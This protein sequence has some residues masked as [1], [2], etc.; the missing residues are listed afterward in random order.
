MNLE[1]SKV[2]TDNSGSIEFAE[3][4]M[5]MSGQVTQSLIDPRFV[6][7]AFEQIY[8]QLFPNKIM[9]QDRNMSSLHLQMMHELTKE[10]RAAR[11]CLP[12]MYKHW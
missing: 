5:L 7:I 11:L 12:Q 8:H 3:F 10:V 4:L 2:D 9:D 1:F 6:A